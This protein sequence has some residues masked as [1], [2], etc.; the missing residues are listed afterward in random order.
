MSC[1][2]GRPWWNLEPYLTPL[3]VLEKLTLFFYFFI[4]IVMFAK[5]WIRNDFG[6]G[7]GRE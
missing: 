2:I 1:S 6:D 3:H 4:I 5:A 7:V